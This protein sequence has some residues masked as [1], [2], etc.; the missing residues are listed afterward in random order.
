MSPALALVPTLKAMSL[1]VVGAD[2][3]HCQALM[4]CT[5]AGSIWET[6]HTALQSLLTQAQATEGLFRILEVRSTNLYITFS[7]SC[8]QKVSL[9]D[10]TNPY[11]DPT[12]GFT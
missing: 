6:S 11:G 7:Y 4:C 3:A 10:M 9:L 2:I 8:Q 5:V 12:F 1:G